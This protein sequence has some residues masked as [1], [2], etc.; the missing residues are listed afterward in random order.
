M[1]V[2]RKTFL[3]EYFL[4]LLYIYLY[5]L[6][7]RKSKKKTVEV[8]GRVDWLVYLSE[9]YTEFRENSRPKS[10]GQGE[11]GKRFHHSILLYVKYPLLLLTLS[12][13]I[14]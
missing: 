13:D 7:D 2:V 9:F 4:D 11:E 3:S 1:T 12:E 10:K 8:K 5:Y 6:N 14:K